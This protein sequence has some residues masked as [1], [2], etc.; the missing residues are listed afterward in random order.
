LRAERESRTVTLA[1]VAE[2]TKIK[3]SLFAGL[4]RGDLTGWPQGLFRRAFVKEYAVAARLD[5]ERVV[6][7]FLWVHSD[8]VSIWPAVERRSRPRSEAPRLT[9]DGSHAFWI[10]DLGVRSL[11]ALAD[12]SLIAFA[13]GVASTATGFTFA[14]LAAAAAVICYPLSLVCL[15]ETAASFAYRWLAARAVRSPMSPPEST[16][17]LVPPQERPTPDRPARRADDVAQDRRSE[18]SKAASR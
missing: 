12:V 1:Q 15:G 10:R 17:R 16:L 11:R 4:E 6:A 13:A 18:R 3:A 2:A 5:P 14:W 8:H 7:E 9:L